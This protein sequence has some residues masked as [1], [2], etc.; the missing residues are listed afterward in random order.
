M[1][2]DEEARLPAFEGAS[3]I[4]FSE[5]TIPTSVERGD[6][7]R[8]RTRSNVIQVT[9][10]ICVCGIVMTLPEIPLGV[11]APPG[12]R[13]GLLGAIEGIIEEVE[14]RGPEAG[15]RS[16]VVPLGTGRMLEAFIQDASHVYVGF[17]SNAGGAVQMEI[18]VAWCDVITLGDHMMRE[19][20]EQLDAR[21]IEGRD[22]AGRSI[23]VGSW[24]SL[25]SRALAIDGRLTT[26]RFTDD[27]LADA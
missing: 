4:S 13:A 3:S 23:M 1:E 21:P 22:P 17:Q 7:D 14:Q 25:R 12:T 11:D 10:V 2:P 6:L 16:H 26:P 20:C 18:R 15:S 27:P 24:E 19:L 5:L 9:L 8:S